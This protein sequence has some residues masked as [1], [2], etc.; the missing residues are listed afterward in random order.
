MSLLIASVWYRKASKKPN[1]AILNYAFDNLK[2]TY[3]PDHLKPIDEICEPDPRQSSF[4]IYDEKL[5]SDKALQL[6]DKRKLIN[7]LKLN[8]NVPE[9]IVTQFETSKNLFLY[10]WFVYRFYPVAEHHVLIC[11]ELA[12]R[13]RFQDELPQEY[14]NRSYPPTLKPLLSYAIDNGYVKNEG[15]SAW[16]TATKRRASY[17]SELEKTREMKEKGLDE[18]KL[19]SSKV[20]IKD[21]D[22]DWNYLNVLMESLPRLRNL[23]AHGTSNLSNQ[24]FTT[25]KIVKE[26]IDQVF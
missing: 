20:E 13:K 25:F 9:K 1:K 16:H 21:E 15:F 19:D 4:I 26:M 10:A 18:I 24:V 3:N 14:W 22:R 2:M 6:S 23:Y 7:Q 5:N 11:L 8:K 17:R 12:F